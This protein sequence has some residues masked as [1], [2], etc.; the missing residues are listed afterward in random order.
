M[1]PQSTGNIRKSTAAGWMGFSRSTGLTDEEL[2][3][4]ARR[5]AMDELADWTI[6]AD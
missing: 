1:A 3:E 4:G 6:W 2:V 5:S